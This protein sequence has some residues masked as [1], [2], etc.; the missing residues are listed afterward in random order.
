M[1]WPNGQKYDGE[2][3]AGEMHGSGVHRWQNGTCRFGVWVK[4]ERQKWTTPES[5][6]LTGPHAARKAAQAKAKERDKAGGGGRRPA[7]TGPKAARSTTPG[8]SAARS[9]SPTKK[10]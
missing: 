2:W 1:L 10:I 4:G 9:Q 7:P 5:F 3:A 6:G 8:K